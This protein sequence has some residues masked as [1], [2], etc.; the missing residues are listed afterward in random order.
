MIILQGIKNN[1]RKKV[2]KSLVKM[3]VCEN[4]QQQ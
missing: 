4:K 2:E 1:G 3:L